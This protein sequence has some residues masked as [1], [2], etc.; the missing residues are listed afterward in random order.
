MNLT[1]KRK[2]YFLLYAFLIVLSCVFI[3]MS[4][5]IQNRVNDTLRVCAVSVVPS[6]FPFMVISSLLTQSAPYLFSGSSGHIP[7]SKMPYPALLALFLGSFCGFPVGIVTTAG[8][9]KRGLITRDEAE[10]LS[11]VSNNAGPAFVI[12]VVGCAFWGSRAIGIK[13]YLIQMIASWILAVF[14]LRSKAADSTA[15]SRKRSAI[16]EL[17]NSAFVSFFG[18]AIVSGALGIIKICAYI[19]FFASLTEAL[20]ILPFEIPKAVEGAL[21]AVLEFTSGCRMGAEIGG[22]SGIVLSSFAI[23]FSGISVLLQGAS[24]A[25]NAGFSLRKT[26]AVKLLQGT[27][28]AIAAFCLI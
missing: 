10:R 7:F 17:S 15:V 6:L 5:D 24:F 1:S 23:G 9:K 16:P 20:R 19:V 4:E 3:I 2:A 11:A 25:S 12:E 22:K 8:L 14:I 26:A 27:I 13:L 21:S 18:E 28:C